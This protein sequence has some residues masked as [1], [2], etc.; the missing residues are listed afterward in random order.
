MRTLT[1]G[2]SSHNRMQRACPEMKLLTFGDAATVLRGQ[3][4]TDYWQ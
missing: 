3:I 1:D 2:G 4:F